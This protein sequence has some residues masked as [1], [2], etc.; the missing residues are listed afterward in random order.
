MIS[1]RSTSS[2][3]R[4]TRSIG[5]FKGVGRVFEVPGP[6]T[7]KVDSGEATKAFRSVYRVSKRRIHSA[8]V[9]GG[10]LNTSKSNSRVISDQGDTSRVSASASPNVSMRHSVSAEQVSTNTSK[11]SERKRSAPKVK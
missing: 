9:V 5:S 8:K 2:V 1:Q 6:I 10:V 7:H 4:P 11:V 3:P